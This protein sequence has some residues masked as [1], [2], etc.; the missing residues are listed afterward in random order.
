MDYI[1]ER[2]IELLEVDGRLTFGEIASRINLSRPAVAART[3]RLISNGHLDVRGAVHPA[4]LGQTY[5][6]YAS[7]AIS[8]PALPVANAVAERHDVPFVS[9]VTGS[10]PVV[11][12]IR[13]SSAET[14]LECVDTI[15]KLNG[16]RS[17]NTLVY[18]SI[19]RD[20]VGPVGDVTTAVDAVDQEL[21]RHLQ[22]DGRISFVNL[23]DSVDLSP[24]GVRRRVR[25]LID[26]NVLR[27]GA[28]VR[29][30]GH[31]RHVA[32]GLAVRV[33]GLRDHVEDELCTLD[34]VIFVAR[35]L[36]YADLLM[37][38]RA[39]SVAQLAHTVDRIRAI[40]GVEDVTSWAH[41]EVVKEAYGALFAH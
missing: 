9:V 10:R 18:H 6:G 38:V 29:H 5:L 4:V 20:V 13:A 16:V 27:V 25:S 21:L 36:G 1:D 23:A 14:Y 34:A 30:S 19:V 40:A 26:N 39:F 3:K 31:D 17:A 41:L 35:T 24:A 33:N 7:L 11:A 28:V 12:E 8:G 37:T 15:R 32:M 22:S 2:I